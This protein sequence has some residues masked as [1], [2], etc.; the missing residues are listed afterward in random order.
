MLDRFTDTA[1]RLITGARERA[2]TRQHYSLTNE[3]LLEMFL[4]ERNCFAHRLILEN[5]PFFDFVNREIQ[6]RLKCAS[7][8]KGK[9]INFDDYCKKSFERAFLL[10]EKLK[11]KGISHRLA[12][13]GNVTG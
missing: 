11:H 2:E 1:K 12:S 3:H 7:K 10:T 13:A 6:S 4:E 5:A 8:E 9:T